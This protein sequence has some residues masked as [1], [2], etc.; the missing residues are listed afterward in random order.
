MKIVGPAMQVLFQTQKTWIHI[1]CFWKA[2]TLHWQ[3]KRLRKR[4]GIWSFNGS[5]LVCL[6]LRCGWSPKEKSD[7]PA[8]LPT[9]QFLSLFCPPRVALRNCDDVCSCATRRQSCG[10]FQSHRAQ[11]HL[12]TWLPHRWI[13]NFFFP[14]ITIP[15]AYIFQIGKR[16]HPCCEFTWGCAQNRWTNSRESKPQFTECFERIASQPDGRR[17]SNYT[18][19]PRIFFFLIFQIKLYTYWWLYATWAD[20]VSGV[21]C[22]CMRPKK[23]CVC[24]CDCQTR[25]TL[26]GLVINLLAFCVL[27]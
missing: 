17:R 14:F 9:K 10:T 20:R 3:L 18:Q 12:I 13:I 27:L 8:F 1:L 19:S 4:K 6:P 26:H 7:D 23:K 25:L 11:P 22:R 16:D 15:F 5:L 2:N 24:V 21:Y